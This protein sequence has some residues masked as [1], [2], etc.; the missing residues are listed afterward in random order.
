M[1]KFTIENIETGKSY[2]AK[3][4]VKT[5]LDDFGRPAPN[6]T[7]IPVKG[8][9]WYE[10]LGIIQVRDSDKKLVQLKDDKSKKE[11]VVPYKDLWD[12][13]EIEWKDPLAS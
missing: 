11:F 12:V 10:G 5:L 4:K 13:D 9:G 2:A 8:E 1:T 7:D 6:L 3:F